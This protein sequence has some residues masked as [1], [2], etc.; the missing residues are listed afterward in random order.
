MFLFHNG[1]QTNVANRYDVNK[2]LSSVQYKTA[3]ETVRELR[4]ML[5][6]TQ[7]GWGGEV[8]TVTSQWKHLELSL[9]G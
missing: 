3:L 6:P 2:E 8:I 1:S 7:P 9:E 4:R 5:C